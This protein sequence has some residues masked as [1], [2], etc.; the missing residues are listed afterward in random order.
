MS[1]IHNDALREQINDEIKDTKAVTMW[2]R[3]EEVSKW[4]SS[5]QFKALTNA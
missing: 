2:K 1:N 3:E 5:P 4:V